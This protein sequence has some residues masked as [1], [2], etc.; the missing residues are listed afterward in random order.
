MHFNK[1]N[2]PIKIS[3]TYKRHLFPTQLRYIHTNQNKPYTLAKH[4]WIPPFNKDSYLI[5]T[6]HILNLPYNWSSKLVCIL[7]SAPFD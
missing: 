6:T 3:T 7:I 2:T 5:Q 1:Y 4:T